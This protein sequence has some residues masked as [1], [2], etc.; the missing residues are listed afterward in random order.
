MNVGGFPNYASLTPSRPTRPT[1]KLRPTYPEEESEIMQVECQA[2]KF[3]PQNIG[4]DNY[5]HGNPS[6]PWTVNTNHHPDSFAANFLPHGLSINTT[7][8]VITGIPT[9]PGSFTIT[10][11]AIET[12]VALARDS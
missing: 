1:R 8:G 11:Y 7:N 4:N 3:T 12:N 9:S 6:L 2:P 10:L 5:S